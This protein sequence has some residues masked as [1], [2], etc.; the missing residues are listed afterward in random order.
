MSGG[1]ISGLTLACALRASDIDVEVVESKPTLSDDGG[2]GLTLV[3]NALRALDTIGLAR[4]I[5]ERGVPANSIRLCMSD[6]T[7]LREQPTAG[8]WG[9]GIPGHCSISRKNLHAVLA[10]TA[11]DRGVRIRTGVH[12]TAS[13]PSPDGL[14][15]TF[16]DGSRGRYRICAA[17]EGLFSD[18]RARL[19][20]GV[21]PAHSGQASWRALVRR[22][23]GLGTSEI[24]LGGKYGVVGVCPI[25]PT[26]AYL[27]IV[28]AAPE[29]HREDD[30]RLHVTMRERLQGAYG[31]RIPALLDQLTD[32][33][34]VSY[35]PLPALIAP[36]PWYR[37]HTVLIG[38]AAHA[39]PPV[40]AQGAAM[41]I[42]DAVVL[43]DELRNH[44]RDIDQILERF[45]ARRYERARSVV[46]SS[47]QLARWEVEHTENVDVP[48]VL[49]QVSRMLAEPI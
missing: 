22:P 14:D 38:D 4:P 47:V 6:G 49:A 3:G 35:R 21:M 15:V 11:I 27:Y 44:A 18:A 19:F 45:M 12:I 43:A 33:A 7:L 32:P 46:D 31:G 48:G 37:E 41:G 10:Q 13:V 5:I 16:S 26:D 17:A 20:P 24:Y 30:E 36:A 2:V 39:N 25:T 34:V 1:G 40:L 29:H 42:E 9:E 23:E 8:P 28:E